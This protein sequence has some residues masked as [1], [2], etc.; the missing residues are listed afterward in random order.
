MILLSKAGVNNAEVLKGATIYAAEWLE[1]DDMY[2]SIEPG[3]IADLVVL[4]ADPLAEISN[5][6]D[7]SGVNRVVNNLR[8]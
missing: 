3:K 4:N 6:Q 5:A 8:E 7:V 1:A 2:G